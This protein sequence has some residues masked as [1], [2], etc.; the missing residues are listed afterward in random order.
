MINYLRY[1]TV[2]IALMR[3]QIAE[4]S[5]KLATK[6]FREPARSWRHVGPK[7][8]IQPSLHHGSMTLATWLGHFHMGSTCM[9]PH[10]S[11]RYRRA[12]KQNIQLGRNCRG[13]PSDSAKHCRHF[14]HYFVSISQPGVIEIQK[15]ISSCSHMYHLAVMRRSIQSNRS[16][17]QRWKYRKRSPIQVASATSLPST[18]CSRRIPVYTTCYP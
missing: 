12:W 14:R 17:A 13:A 2:N 6:W 5:Q 15:W 9:S 4:R 16:L 7:C 11:R 8:S 1:S 18:K 10:C 3:T